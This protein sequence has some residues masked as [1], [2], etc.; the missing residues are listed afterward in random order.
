MRWFRFEFW[1]QSFWVR[2]REI[3]ETGILTFFVRNLT[4][5]DGGSKF[6]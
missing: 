1:G 4:D 2:E 6:N 5:L 3:S